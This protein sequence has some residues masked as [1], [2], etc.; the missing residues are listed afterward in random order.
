MSRTLLKPCKYP[1][2]IKFIWDFTGIVSERVYQFW[3][4]FL[5]KAGSRDLIVAKVVDYNT[6][7]GRLDV[8]FEEVYNPR[9]VL[10]ELRVQHEKIRYLCR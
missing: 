6:I 10:Q 1:A 7:D 5:K 3:N 4:P 9:N 2:Y 8:L